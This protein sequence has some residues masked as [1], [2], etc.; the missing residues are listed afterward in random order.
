[1]RWVEPLRNPP[2]ALRA[3]PKQSQCFARSWTGGEVR[4][5][6]II[7]VAGL[8]AETDISG[9]PTHAADFMRHVLHKCGPRSKFRPQ[10]QQTCLTE[11]Y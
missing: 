5:V 9:R 10:S 6:S 8:K 2:C 1:M 3:F 7:A 11:S 4:M